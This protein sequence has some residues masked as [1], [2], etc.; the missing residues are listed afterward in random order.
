MRADIELCIHSWSFICRTRTN[1]R[2]E[3]KQAA[4]RRRRRKA[5]ALPFSPASAKGRKCRA[6]SSESFVFINQLYFLD[7]DRT[8]PVSASRNTES[9]RCNMQETKGKPEN[10][11]GEGKKCESQIKR[12]SSILKLSTDPVSL[13]DSPS[14][15]F[16]PIGIVESTSP[17]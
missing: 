1:D 5:L 7:E 9:R 4:R 14:K 11:N 17:V 10:R 13:P 12:G 2:F 15:L 16:E 3:T 8:L 6:V